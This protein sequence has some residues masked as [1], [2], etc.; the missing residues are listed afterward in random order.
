VQS[1]FYVGAT[2][3]G[4][5]AIFNGV[6]G[7]IVGIDLSSVVETSAAR[8]DDLTEVAQDRVKGGIQADSHVDAQRRLAELTSSDPSNPNLKPLC[9]PNGNETDCRTD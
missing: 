9:V 1:Q 8:I 5:I 7:S 6:P 2:E 4:Q 3:S